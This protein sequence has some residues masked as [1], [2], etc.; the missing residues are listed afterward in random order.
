MLS[1]KGMSQSKIN[2]DSW[3]PPSPNAAE[4]LK[5]GNVPVGMLTGTPDIGFDLYEIN[6]GKLKVPIRLSYHASGIRVNQKSTDVGLGW[7]VQAGGVISRTIFGSPDEKSNGYFNYNP[8]TIVDLMQNNNFYDMQ[9]YTMQNGHHGKDLAPDIFHYSFPGKSGKFICKENKEFIAIPYEPLKISK[10]NIPS[11]VTFKIIDESGNIYFFN[12]LAYTEDTGFP[13]KRHANSWYLSSIVSADLTDTVS[14]TYESIYVEDKFEQ[15][16]QMFGQKFGGVDQFVQLNQST[17]SFTDMLLKKISFKNGYAEFKRN[18]FRKDTWPQSNMLDEL[19]IY[20][21]HGVVI[22]KVSFDHGYFKASP[23]S[24]NYANYRL[25]L[26][27]FTESDGTGLTTLPHKFGYNTTP[28][29]P[30]NSYNLDYWGYFNGSNNMNL[31]PAQQVFGKD[32]TSVTFNVGGSFNQPNIGPYTIFNFGSANRNANETFM[33]ACMLDT[34]IYPTKGFTRFEYEP[35]K[36]YQDQ[37]NTQQVTGGGTTAGI[38][39]FTLSTGTFNISQPS[40]QPSSGANLKITFSV[41]NMG[42]T[43]MGETQKVILKNLSNNTILQT[44][45]HTGDLTVPLIINY[46]FTLPS[47]ANYQIIHEVYGPAAVTVK[48]EVVWTQ[49]TFQQVVLSGGGLRI[50]SINKYSEA[51]VVVGQEDYVYGE[52][53]DGIGTKMFKDKHFY[54]NYEDFIDAVYGPIVPT[55]IPSSYCV[56]QNTYWYRNYIG[57]A[58]HTAPSY[59][60]SPV[61]YKKVTKLLNSGSL[62][63]G[64]AVYKYDVKIDDTEAPYEFVNGGN[65]GNINNVWNQGNLLEEETYKFG[66]GL[67]K[68]V[69]RNQYEYENFPKPTQNAVQLKQFKWFIKAGG[70]DTY[71]EGPI[72]NSSTPGQG[73]FTFYNYAI[74]TGASKISKEIKT[75]YDSGDG[76]T[77]TASTK[78]YKYANTDH[79]FPTKI[80]SA[81]SELDSTVTKLKYPVDVSSTVNNYMVTNNIISP[82][83]ENKVYKKDVG[84]TETLLSTLQ[85]DYKL[86]GTAVLKDQVKTSTLS[87]IP[88]TR[89]LYTAYDTRGNVRE[90]QFASGAKEVYLWG[91]KSQYPVA[92]ILN[93]DFTSV[94]LAMSQ[95]AVTQTLLDAAGSSTDLA[96]RTLL[97]KLRTALPN[98]HIWTYTYT[99]LVGVTSQTDAK[100]M[101]TYYEYDEFQRLKNIKD[102][103][104][105]IVKNLDY[106]YKP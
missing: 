55:S 102:Q 75:V 36:Y 69:A 100:G 18:N 85:T 101:T 60:G 86:I 78:L 42:N 37:T 39:K 50:K 87:D 80:A 73:F 1:I 32:L 51:N 23:F 84:G 2:L 103:N 96:L 29:P 104:G 45:V 40:N 64:K 106:H 105:N 43:E 19:I 9:L 58:N 49:D 38:S 81:N 83:I 47:G 74:K 10:T 88:E 89:I 30:I 25:R 97:N 3:I 27:G 6:T 44:W 99:P 65:Y 59:S 67:Y 72:P 53:E 4:I 26:N 14:F 61:L 28:L 33:Q 8:P 15:H 93:S 90:Q 54:R 41:S 82:L 5:Y 71:P 92:K 56:L 48:S 17:I 11:S 70:C 98:A 34:V 95:Q 35:H 20:N 62:N 13:A 22:K 46:P 31:I 94:S 66:G 16:T 91:Y 68:L 21:V 77:A 57:M 12:D 7:S 76:S 79:L 52:N 63:G 24:D